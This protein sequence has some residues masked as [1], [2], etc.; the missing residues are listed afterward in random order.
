MFPKSI[1]MRYKK[2]ILLLGILIFLP[3]YLAYSG[4]TLNI[5]NFSIIFSLSITLV[6]YYIIF[7]KYNKI[8]YIKL[9]ALISSIPLYFIYLLFFY[10]FVF[11]KNYTWVDLNIINFKKPLISWVESELNDL[12]KEKNRK[13]AD[14]QEESGTPLIAEN[15]ESEIEFTENYEDEYEYRNEE[16]VQAYE[17]YD[18]YGDYESE[19][20]S[21]YHVVDGYTRS[22]GVEVDS[23]VRGDPDGVEENNIEYM[24][25]HGDQD[26]LEQAYASL[27]D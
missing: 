16:E 12:H 9:L 23:Y 14:I 26:G 3:I 1:V 4:L 8:I 5:F 6:C 27:F 22:D 21:G 17:E 24:R 10:S 7:F 25:D 20:Q 15:S 19:N 11:N 2:D 18:S 13:L